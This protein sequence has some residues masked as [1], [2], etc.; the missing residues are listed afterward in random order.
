MPP[1]LWA[2]DDVLGF[3]VS[4]M[5]TEV[6]CVGADSIEIVDANT[7]QSLERHALTGEVSCIAINPAERRYC[8]ATSSG[9]LLTGVI[10]SAESPE[11]IR[12]PFPLDQPQLGWTYSGWIVVN[13]HDAVAISMDG[14]SVYPLMTRWVDVNSA[15]DDVRLSPVLFE[16][17][18]PVT[19]T[20]QWYTWD[21]A[22]QVPRARASSDLASGRWSRR[23]RVGEQWLHCTGD[24]RPDENAIRAMAERAGL[25]LRQQTDFTISGDGAVIGFADVSGVLRFF[26]SDGTLLSRIHLE[27]VPVCA[28]C[29]DETGHTVHLAYRRARPRRPARCAWVILDVHTGQRLFRRSWKGARRGFSLEQTA[30]GVIGI[31]RNEVVDIPW[32]FIPISVCPESAL[33]KL[34]K[35]VA[36]RRTDLASSKASALDGSFSARLSGGTEGL[37]TNGSGD[38]VRRYK[39]A[40]YI[41]EL[42]YAG[43]RL[44]I[45]TWQADA[46]IADRETGDLDL[47]IRF[48]WTQLSPTIT[49]LSES[50]MVVTFKG[51]LRVIDLRAMS[52]AGPDRPALDVT[53]VLDLPK[54][55][56]VLTAWRGGGVWLWSVSD[57]TPSMTL[58]DPRH[59]IRQA[60]RSACERYV[61]LQTTGMFADEQQWV[62]DLQSGHLIARF[63]VDPRRPV[64]C[65]AEFSSSLTF[66]TTLFP[67]RGRGR[68]SGRPRFDVAQEELPVTLQDLDWTE[69]RERQEH[70]SAVD[71]ASKRWILEYPALSQTAR[72]GRMCVVGDETGQVHFLEVMASEPPPTPSLRRVGCRGDEKGNP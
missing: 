43:S 11:V 15:M 10:G 31:R 9:E 53:L 57:G 51:Y 2:R 34:G 64:D 67:S 54:R 3:S 5:N 38:E 47:L 35:P 45:G 8:A 6:F 1:V 23:T 72:V 19:G 24:V 25:D 28:W 22:T 27:T 7:G 21:R 18:V 4:G 40:H 30:R 68:S 39:T 62:W 48:P 56:Q 37:E 63:N 44:V 32:R 61:C 14:K 42:A 12:L 59:K 20:P 69:Y 50:L 41:G 58:R 65:P 36:I 66:H 49:P 46:L 55:G 16:L 60:W 52:P 13:E 29:L 33:I 17:A 70:L 71:H 26:R